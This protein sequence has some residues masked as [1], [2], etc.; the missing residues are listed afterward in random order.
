MAARDG[1][2]GGMRGRFLRASRARVGYIFRVGERA[3][4]FL[5][6]ARKILE[7]IE[8]PERIGKMF[9]TLKRFVSKADANTRV[10][11]D[12]IFGLHRGDE[13]PNQTYELG[14]FLIQVTIGCARFSR[15][16]LNRM[17]ALYFESRER[18]CNR[19]KYSLAVRKN[20]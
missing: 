13:I 18:L 19:K 9:V 14:S 20:R 5:A 11:S 17:F 2:G 1:I 7:I 15:A 10:N 4:F 16:G 3:I 8:S 6:R 12:V